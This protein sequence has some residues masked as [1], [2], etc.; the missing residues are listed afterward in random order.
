MEGSF[1]NPL[2]A[3]R[4]LLILIGVANFCAS[5][6]LGINFLRGHMRLRSDSSQ[7]VTI[8]VAIL[9]GVMGCMFA[10]LSLE[11]FTNMGKGV[12]IVMVCDAVLF[13]TSLLGISKLTRSTRYQ[14]VDK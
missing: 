11:H 3:V 1:S 10:L 7:Q 13:P 5:V 12:T 8:W 9:W 14:F 6:N 4:F 2:D